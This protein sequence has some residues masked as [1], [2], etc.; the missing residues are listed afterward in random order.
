[1]DESWTTSELTSGET[2]QTAETDDSW[3]RGVTATV[4]VMGVVVMVLAQSGCSDGQSWDDPAPST[5][6]ERY[7]MAWSQNE[8]DKAYD[9]IDPAD[10]ELL[11]AP[12]DELQA[13][14]P[15]GEAPTSSEMLVTGRIDHPFDLEDVRLVDPPSGGVSSG[16]TVQLELLYFDERS[17]EAQLVWRED[18]WFV[19]LPLEEE[20]GENDEA[21][22]ESE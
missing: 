12:L 18:Q 22:S 21:S 16:E 9:M 5:V 19:D 13:V 14:A 11:E 1:M 8:R 10:R 3:N 7:L 2:D 20:A 15:D 17:G 4:I 6:F